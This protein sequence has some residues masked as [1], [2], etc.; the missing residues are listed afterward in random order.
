MSQLSPT[1]DAR[2]RAAGDGEEWEGDLRV[3]PSPP[4]A[5]MSYRSLSQCLGLFSW[6]PGDWVCSGDPGP[7]LWAGQVRY[8]AALRAQPCAVPA[9]L[10]GRAGWLCCLELGWARRQG[11][12]WGAGYRCS[13]SSQRP[14]K[15]WRSQSGVK[16]RASQVYTPQ[17]LGAGTGMW[18]LHSF[19]PSAASPP[20]QPLH[21]S[22]WHM[23]HQGA[24]PPPASILPHRSLLGGSEPLCPPCRGEGGPAELTAGVPGQVGSRMVCPPGWVPWGASQGQVTDGGKEK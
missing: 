1:L 21:R 11:W 16:S 7:G 23:G 6:A 4:L 3:L 20:P 22:M 14:P 12:Q 17:K 19:L 9:A 5:R 2:G 13:L 24:V 10:P 15:L 18:G 8:R